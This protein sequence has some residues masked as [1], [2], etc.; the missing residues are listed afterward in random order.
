M[1]LNGKEKEAEFSGRWK[2]LIVKYLLALS[3]QL[4]SMG[5]CLASGQLEAVKFFAH[6]I[7]GTSGTYGL[8]D[9]AGCAKKIEIAAELGDIHSTRDGIAALS[10]LIDARLGSL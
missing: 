7:K 2:E 1:R 9:I 6:Q 5:D 3:D 10:T 8:D 4:Q